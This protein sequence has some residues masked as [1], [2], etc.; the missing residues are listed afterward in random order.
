MVLLSLAW[1]SLRNRALVSAL[2]VLSIA[3]SVT[4]LVGIENVRAGV[5]DSFA[6][7]IRGT[8]LIVGAR[9]GTMQVLMSSVF[10]MATPAGALSM[11]TYEKWKAHPAVKW[12]IPYSLGDSHRGFRVIGTTSAFY[13][14][15][16]FRTERVTF[17]EGRAA[18]ADDEV[19]IGHDVA[20]RLGYVVGQ[21]VVVAHGTGGVT[22]SEHGAHPF[23]VVGIIARTFTPID[24]ALYVTLTGIEAMHGDEAAPPSAAPVSATAPGGAPLVMP[25]SGGPPAG[26]TAPGGAPLVMP[27]SD[28]P[29]A[30]ATAPGGAPLV[31]PGSSG[32]PVAPPPPPTPPPTPP[33]G[34]ASESDHD[35]DN[36]AHGEEGH[37][38]AEGDEHDHET[39]K[40]TAFFVGTQTRLET[41]TLQRE[42]NDDTTE[43]LTAIVPG[44]ALAELWQGIGNAEV[45]LKVVASFTVLIGLAGMLVSLYSSLDAR[46]RE[47]AILRAVGA[48]PRT[49]IG[50]LVL[51]SGMLALLGAMLGV[52]LVYAVLT[53]AQGPIENRFGLLIPV[54]ALGAT[55][56][57]YLALIVG[58]GFLV[59]LVPAWKA[60]RSSLADG[61]SPRT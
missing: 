38:H 6:G 49:I 19:A 57:G 47:M 54:R 44:V 39:D 28:G 20:A 32:P 14:H 50:L 46:R 56:W 34:G 52:V 58:A 22:F 41:L 27:G 53:L 51:E 3:L 35:H 5:R 40:I 4:L 23:T 26:A 60:Y 10:G 16:R 59:G 13:E 42:M 37:E 29:P 36:P 11:D 24:R 9:G 15:Y 12:T 45:G 30:G 43:P 17:A 55:E 21:K 8:D 48:R 18:Q 7:T 61:L 2:T 33:Q 31:M 1:R 25:G